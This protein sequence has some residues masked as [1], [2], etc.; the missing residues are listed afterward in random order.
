M[1]RLACLVS[2][3]AS[4]FACDGG[5]TTTRPSAPAELVPALD[6]FCD[7]FERCPDYYTIGARDRGE[8]VDILYWLFTCRIVETGGDPSGVERVELMIDGPEAQACADALRGLSCEDLS[9]IGEGSCG[10]GLEACV[11]LFSNFGSDDGDDDTLLAGERCYQYSSERC[12]PGL[13]CADQAYDDASESVLCSVCA[14]LLAEGAACNPNREDAQ[15]AAGFGCFATDEM[16]TEGECQ[17]LLADG[18]ACLRDHECAGGFCAGDYPDLACS[19]GGNAGDPC[20]IRSDCRWNQLGAD[21]ITCVGDTCDVPRQQGEA[22]PNDD[23]CRSFHCDPSD[24]RCGVPE[25]GA[26]S[27]SYE[28]REGFCDDRTCAPL[29]GNGESCT[30]DSGACASGYCDGTMCASPPP[31]AGV[32]ESCSTRED[33]NIGLECNFVC[34]VP[35]NSELDCEDGEICDEGQCGA[36]RENGS[37]CDRD[38]QCGSNYCSDDAE[39]CI[40]KP[41]IGD[42][43]SG[44]SDCY[45]RGYCSGGVCVERR[46]PDQACDSYDSCLEPYLCLNSVCT[47]ISLSC[48]PGTEGNPCT[49]LRF[50]DESTYCDFTTFTCAPRL[51]AGEFCISTFDQCASGFYCGPSGTCDAQAAEGEACTNEGQCEAPT[52]CVDGTCQATMSGGA[53]DH[54]DAECPIGSYCEDETCQPYRDVGQA[55]DDPFE[56]LCRPELFC[57]NDVCTEGPGAGEPCASGNECRV[58]FW[59]DVFSSSTCQPRDRLGEECETSPYQSCIEGTYCDYDSDRMLYVCLM[60]RANG[61][62]CSS[63]STSGCISGFCV[64]GTCSARGE[65]VVP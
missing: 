63:G 41:G 33:C 21:Y 38:E 55:C 26:C 19:S 31:R 11:S 60:G 54:S 51:G 52:F 15:C 44:F 50:C 17:P 24:D 40:D 64:D 2:F 6:A 22:C 58:G 37:S 10:E 35:C 65:C 42:A 47:L 29:R 28:C 30:D 61:E 39:V 9:C 13:F 46:G 7:L 16:R 53:C 59:C 36:L 12:G 23:A 49:Y 4:L 27:S 62:S 57:E 3:A 14:P 48:E 56:M 18:E 43:C 45:P 32:G 25:G 34:Y 5:G 20:T 1:R 8:C